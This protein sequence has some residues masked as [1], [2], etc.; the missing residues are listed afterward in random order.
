MTDTGERVLKA[1]KVAFDV[2]S[3]PCELSMGGVASSLIDVAVLLPELQDKS[4]CQIA[5][6]SQHSLALDTNGQVYAWGQTSY[7]KLGFSVE[8]EQEDW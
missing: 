6:G 2:E 8:G 1:G 5:S 7:S 3:T 4:I